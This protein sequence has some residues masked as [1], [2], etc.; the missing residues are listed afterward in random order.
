MRSTSATTIVE[1]QS[2]LRF[3][4]CPHW[5]GQELL[6]LD[7]DERCIKS[8]SINGLV[9][10]VQGLPYVPGCFSVLIDG[11]FIVSDAWRRTMFRLGPAGQQQVADIS[12]LAQ[13]CLNDVVVDSCGGI[14]VCDV[15][16][17]FQDPLVDPMPNGTIIY[18]SVDGTSSVVARDLFSPSGMIIIP[19]RRTLIVAETLGHRLTAFDISSEGGLQN[20]RVWAQFHDDI[21]P[22][23][24]CL[25]TGGGIWVA[26]AVPHAIRV[27]EGGEIDQKI[28]TEQLVFATALGGPQGRS[29][30][31]C[32]CDSNDPVMTRRAYNA[33]IEVA[34]VDTAGGKVS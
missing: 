22:I 6:F 34:E 3:A 24:I 11:A 23:G 33:T 15:G 1:T 4:K 17:D 31:L 28:S 20:S 27:S 29:L 12:S 7:V 26:G 9:Q 21:T 25:D 5:R 18:I 13:F 30:F 2:G 19:D 10:T 14:Y 16:Y 8:A 32:T